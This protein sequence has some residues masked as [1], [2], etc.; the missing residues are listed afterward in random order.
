MG[1]LILH[2]ALFIKTSDNSKTKK[3]ANLLDIW[4]E[5]LEIYSRD[6]FFM[7]QT[8]SYKFWNHPSNC[9]NT[10]PLSD[11]PLI[12]NIEKLDEEYSRRSVYDCLFNSTYFQIELSKQKNVLI[13]DYMKKLYDSLFNGDGPIDY[14]WIMNNK[15]LNFVNLTE[16]TKPINMVADFMKIWFTLVC[17]ENKRAGFDHPSFMKGVRSLFCRCYQCKT[18]FAGD[19]PN[20]Y[21]LFEVP[22][23]KGSLTKYLSEFNNFTVP[24]YVKRVDKNCACMSKQHYN[25]TNIKCSAQYKELPQLLILYFVGNFGKKTFYIQQIPQILR[26]FPFGR[27][28][29]KSF[30]TFRLGMYCS[31]VLESGKWILSN[32]LGRFDVTENLDILLVEDSVILACFD[33]EPT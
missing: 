6:L 4:R 32:R 15:Y 30:V 24:G 20:V 13:I 11:S 1:M 16:P 9:L 14:W 28:H 25:L 17:D 21:S 12:P 2:F 29:L 7:H 26:D 10:E 19:S 27:Y 8:I 5:P 3:T 22:R 33:K 31:V 23:Y 18:F